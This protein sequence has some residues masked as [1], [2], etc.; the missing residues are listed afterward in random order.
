MS[1][2]RNKEQGKSDVILEEPMIILN[3]R[4]VKNSEAH[5]DSRRFAR[6]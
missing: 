5:R 1:K 3:N 2:C 6:G 4:V